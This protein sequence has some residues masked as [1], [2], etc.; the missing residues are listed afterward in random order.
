ME[1]ADDA[2]VA[3]ARLRLGVVRAL[4][5]TP[6]GSG[7][8]KP[9]EV[10][11]LFCNRIFR[12]QDELSKFKDCPIGRPSVYKT[13]ITNKVQGSSVDF[14]ANCS[15]PFKRVEQELRDKWAGTELPEGLVTAPSRLLYHFE[16][17]D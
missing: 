17:P 11:H 7:G 16:N 14:V 5:I 2:I 3:L 9:N 8:K 10:T 6:L 15:P 4:Q 1:Q 13:A 12:I